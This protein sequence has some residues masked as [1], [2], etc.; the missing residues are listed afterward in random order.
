MNSNTR[1]SL[2]SWCNTSSRLGTKLIR[3]GGGGWRMKKFKSTSLAS[4]TRLYLG[5]S[6]PL[7]RIS[8]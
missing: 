2:Q 7:V 5:A 4:L 3:A 6:V 8:L 1:Y